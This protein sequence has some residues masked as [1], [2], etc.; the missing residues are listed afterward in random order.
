MYWIEHKTPVLT[1]YID[2]VK[3]N[4]DKFIIYRSYVKTQVL[5]TY[6]DGAK[7]NGD[8]WKY[9]GIMLRPR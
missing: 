3:L 4:G 8:N 5:T 1:T 7:V 9:I 2:G 6:I